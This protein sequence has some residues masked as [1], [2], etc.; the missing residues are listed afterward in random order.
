MVVT[1]EPGVYMVPAIWSNRELTGSF[2]DAVNRPA[3]EQLLS[4]N[5]GGIRIEQTIRVTA[6][7]PPEVLTAELPTTADDVAACVGV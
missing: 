3:V 5:F 1:I 7:G 6:D 4:Q 2:E